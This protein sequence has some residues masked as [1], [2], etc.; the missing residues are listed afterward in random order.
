L[1]KNRFGGS[2]ASPMYG[3]A[4]TNPLSTKNIVTATRPSNSGKKLR[5]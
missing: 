1:N 5:A 4:S 3:R 2:T